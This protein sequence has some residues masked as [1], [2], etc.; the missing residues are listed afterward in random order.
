MWCHGKCLGLQEPAGPICLDSPWPAGAK[1]TPWGCWT[2]Q[3]Q[4]GPGF[5]GACREP[6]CGSYLELWMVSGASG[7]QS[8][9]MSWCLDLWEPAE[10]S[11]EPPGAGAWEK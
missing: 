4:W 5:L 7:L 6:C 10:E 9:E 3:G 11:Q 1:D 8:T 2:C